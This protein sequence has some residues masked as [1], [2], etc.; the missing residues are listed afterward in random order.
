MELAIQGERFSHELL[1]N[2]QMEVLGFC[3]IVGIGDGAWQGMDCE[4]H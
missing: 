3:R 2:S 4:S 1:T